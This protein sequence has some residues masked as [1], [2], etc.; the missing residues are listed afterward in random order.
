MSEK[1]SSP[2]L[3]YVVIAGGLLG[4]GW[5]LW[6]WLGPESASERYDRILAERRAIEARAE[7]ARE[8]R[9]EVSVAAARTVVLAA[10]KDPSSAQFG[11]ASVR[12][13]G[14]SGT[15]VCGTVNARNSFGGYAGPQRYVVHPGGLVLEEAAGAEAMTRAWSRYCE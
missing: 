9:R 5:L 6:A 12:L 4:I 11:P 2:A 8:R 15:A 10:L 1:V 14:D 7:D 13:V 3:G